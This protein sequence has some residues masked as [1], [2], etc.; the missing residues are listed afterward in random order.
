LDQLEE[1]KLLWDTAVQATKAGLPL[2]TFLRRNGWTDEQIA[3]YEGSPERQSR[4][5]GMEAATLGLQSLR[6]GEAGVGDQGA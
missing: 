2:G 5:A 4:V 3:E 6:G 1:E